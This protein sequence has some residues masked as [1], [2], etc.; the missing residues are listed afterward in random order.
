MELIT[1]SSRD[2]L[3]DENLKSP[4]VDLFPKGLSTL[5]FTNKKVIFLTS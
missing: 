2:G 3:T 1:I 4:E 5:K